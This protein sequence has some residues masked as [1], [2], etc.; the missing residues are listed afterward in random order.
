MKYLSWITHHLQLVVGMETFCYLL[1]TL[2]ILSPRNYIVN[3]SFL[4]YNENG[5]FG[6]VVP[7]CKDGYGAFYR[8][9]ATRLVH[10]LPLSNN[11]FPIFSLTFTIS[12]YLDDVTNGDEFC[13]NL[14]YSLDFIKNVI[15]TNE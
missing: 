14:E 4:G 8:I 10:Q 15:L 3:Y 7:M 12:N 6:Y 11:C 2:L 9:N 5:C 1:G 13:E